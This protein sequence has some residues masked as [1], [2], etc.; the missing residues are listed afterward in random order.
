MMNANIDRFWIR[1]RLE[2]APRGTRNNLAQHLGIDPNK[3]TK[4]LNGTREVQQ[5]EVPKLLSFFNARIITDNDLLE[6]LEP[7]EA[8][9]LKA[10]RAVPAER[11]SDA[12]RA[13]LATVRLAAPDT[14]AEPQ[15][16]GASDPPTIP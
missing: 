3:L 15:E 4:I 8:D 7:I 9:L 5:D 6:G 14:S 16:D 12:A 2:G 13:A 1:E 10:L 11:R